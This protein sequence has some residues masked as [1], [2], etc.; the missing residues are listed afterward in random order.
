MSYF[1][2]GVV[3]I[4]VPAS[5]VTFTMV[6]NSKMSFNSSLETLRK[7]NDGSLVLFK[8]KDPVDS[9][10]NNY[11]WHNIESINLELQKVEWSGED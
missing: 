9:S 10:F 5:E 3:Y 2:N 8:V 11:Q 4:I 7:S 1:S 6:N